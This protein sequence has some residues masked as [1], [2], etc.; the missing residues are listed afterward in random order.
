MTDLIN[1]IDAL[2]KNDINSVQAIVNKY[3]TVLQDIKQEKQ[4]PYLAYIID[5]CVNHINQNHKD[6]PRDWKA[7]SVVVVKNIYTK[8]NIKCVEDIIKTIDEFVVF[9]KSDY[10]SYCQDTISATEYDRD[11]GFVF[12][13]IIKRNR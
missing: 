13:F 8:G 12:G 5:V 6:L 3:A 11:W 7:W 10:K 9:W 1:K 4:I 2:I